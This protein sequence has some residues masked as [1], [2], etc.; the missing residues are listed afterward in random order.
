MTNYV[1]PTRDIVNAFSRFDTLFCF[2]TGGV[3]GV[4]GDILLHS[5]AWKLLDNEKRI[6]T[7]DIIEKVTREYT[8]SAEAICLRF[9]ENIS[10]ETDVDIV[11]EM[12][13]HAVSEMMYSLFFKLTYIV[14]KN[15]VRWIGDDIL[16][17]IKIL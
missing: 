8:N 9:S 5:A 12:I 14:N 10:Y 4:I 13:D 7:N 11:L 2:Y 3:R 1:L 15:K 16:V 6:T 17:E